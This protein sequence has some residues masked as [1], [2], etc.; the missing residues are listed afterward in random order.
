VPEKFGGDSASRVVD[1][2]VANIDYAPTLVDLSGTEPC[3]ETGDCRVM[4]GRSL[5]PLLAGEGATWPRDRPL[6]TELDLQKDEVQ[7]G[8]G[9][10]CRFEGVREGRWLFIDHTA[11]PD[12]ATGACE[13][14]DVHELYDHASDPF[15]L[16]N[17]AGGAS[18]AAIEERLAAL[19]AEL[20]DCAG[21]EGRDPEPDSGHYC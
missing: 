12:L 11:V 4:D 3:P 15:E 17:L 7:P 2:P 8:R 20:S 1:E 5:T 10:S 13:E 9:I 6:L 16:R 18:S 19:T 14:A 21:I